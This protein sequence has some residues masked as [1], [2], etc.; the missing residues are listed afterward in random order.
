[1]LIIKSL[2][3]QTENESLKN[4]SHEMSDLLGRSVRAESICR[5]RLEKTIILFTKVVSKISFQLL[6][7]L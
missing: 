1:M 2:A 6:C 3:I 4:D 7:S 5:D